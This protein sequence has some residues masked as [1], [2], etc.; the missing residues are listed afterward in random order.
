[1]KPITSKL[2]NYGTSIF[3]TSQEKQVPSTP[4][5]AD[6]SHLV[7][8]LIPCKNEELAISE[9]IVQFR[10]ELPDAEIIVCDNNSTDRTAEVART[11]GAKVLFE[12]RAGKGNAIRK[13]FGATNRDICV[14]VD[15][16]ATYTSADIHK[17]IQPVI[18]GDADMVVGR[19]VTPEQNLNKAYR[20]GHQL[21][22]LSF[23][24][25]MSTMFKY[26]LVDVFSGYRVMSK[27]F[28]KSFPCLSSGFE[29]ETE[30][31]VHALDLG[32]SL[33]EID[34]IYG[35]RTD[36][37]VSKLNTLRD[38]S[39]IALILLHL[40]AQVKPMRF[41][42]LISIVLAV[43]SLILGIPVILDFVKSGL[44]PRF[45]TAILASAVMLLS[46][47]TLGAGLILD[48]VSR[49]RKETKRL[50]YL[51]LN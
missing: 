8:V 22:N 25:A 30:L 4:P 1:M 42:G 9:V 48:S 37:S 38:G 28:V 2:E 23:S 49:G 26:P 15:G 47:L 40:F 32:L 3:M 21:G 5:M 18:S 6:Y 10:K 31:T 12:S 13:L 33:V 36:G 34:S 43:A 46:A 50:F 7:A 20:I 27:R 35:S 45:P 44:V 39:R 11:A 16:D 51:S 41:Y 14:M 24:W 19:R 29:I 17:L